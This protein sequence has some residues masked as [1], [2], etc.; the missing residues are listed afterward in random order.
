MSTPKLN[1]PRPRGRGIRFKSCYLSSQTEPSSKLLAEGELPLVRRLQGK[2]V[3]RLMNFLKHNYPS[4]VSE[5]A[6]AEF[7]VWQGLPWNSKT[8]SELDTMFIPW[9]L[10]NWV[11]NNADLPG[12][13]Y[14]P[15][16]P[17]ALYYLERKGNLLDKVLQRFIQEACNQFFSFFLVTDVQPGYGITVRDIFL[18]RE[19]A[20]V[21]RRGSTSI[22]SGQI[23]FARIMKLDEHWVQFGMSTKAFSNIHY[24]LLVKIREKLSK[25]TSIDNEFLDLY[26]VALRRLYYTL[27]GDLT[28]DSAG[29][30]VVRGKTPSRKE[31]QVGK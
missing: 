9:L 30:F 24:T 31:K 4:Y 27:R 17:I 15:E 18:D 20:L 13:E 16:M 25:R 19:V 29:N 12:H 28:V 7:T 23:L 6:W 14:L 2:L 8:Q 11:P 5:E 1:K 26:D 3:K 21:D 22:K 10:F